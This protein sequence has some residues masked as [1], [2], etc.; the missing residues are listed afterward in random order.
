MPRKNRQ[1]EV[2]RSQRPLA[3]PTQRLTSSGKRKGGLGEGAGRRDSNKAGQ[4][5]PVSAG[6][7]RWYPTTLTPRDR[8]RDTPRDS[9]VAKEKERIIQKAGRTETE[10]TPHVARRRPRPDPGLAARRTF[11]PPGGARACLPGG[12]R[13]E[14]V[15]SQ[16]VS[17]G[18][19]CSSSRPRG[20]WPLAVRGLSPQRWHQ[21]RPPAMAARRPLSLDPV[22]ILCKSLGL[23]S[24]I[25]RL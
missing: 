16:A 21:S 12:P 15:L 8:T 24:V 23:R 4:R 3:P 22:H 5:G 17:P 14:A 13:G 2:T 1:V 11:T 10:V 25:T 20:P 7:G 18:S 9:G 6:R 19:S